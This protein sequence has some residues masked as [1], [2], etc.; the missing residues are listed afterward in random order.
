MTMSPF[1][2]NVPPASPIGA[3]DMGTDS[4]L[5]KG[6]IAREGVLLASDMMAHNRNGYT[7][8]ALPSSMLVSLLNLQSS[9]AMT[10]EQP[11]ERLHVMALWMH[12]LAW[13][14]EMMSLLMDYDKVPVAL[15]LTS[16]SV[17]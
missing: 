4:Q 15:A 14:Q 17:I 5:S 10:S 7:C 16:T 1:T 11:N 3:P 8:A 13:T 12:H 2:V 9:V 6:S